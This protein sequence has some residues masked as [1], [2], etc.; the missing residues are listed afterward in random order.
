LYKQLRESVAEKFKFM[1]RTGIGNWDEQA[2]QGEG[3]EDPTAINR[4]LHLAP[5]C[6]KGKAEVKTCWEIGCIDRL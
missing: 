1:F 5:R 4:K 3:G 2:Q 6:R